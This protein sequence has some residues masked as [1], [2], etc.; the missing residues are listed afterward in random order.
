MESASIC[1]VRGIW[2]RV[3]CVALEAKNVGILLTSQSRS[4]A[5]PQD[6]GPGK[7]GKQCR[8]RKAI[9]NKKRQVRKKKK[10]RHSIKK[11]PRAKVGGVGDGMGGRESVCAYEGPGERDGC[12]RDVFPSVIRGAGTSCHSAGRG[13]GLVVAGLVV[14]QGRRTAN[15]RWRGAL[16]AFWL[17]RRPAQKQVVTCSSSSSGPSELTPTS[18]GKL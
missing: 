16:K 6:V 11:P 15:R 10:K 14:G 4:A 7:R 3:Y 2:F 1:E 13:L 12:V 5:L 18:T 17:E 9:C 8:V